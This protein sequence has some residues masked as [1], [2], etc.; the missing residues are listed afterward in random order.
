[1][2]EFNWVPVVVA[3]VGGG[4]AGAV[5]TQTVT[6]YRNRRQPVG[7]RIQVTPV[8]PPRRSP[9]EL[10]AAIAVTHGGQ[11]ATFENL[12]LVEVQLI[13]KGTPTSRNFDLA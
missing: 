9:G 6:T 3:L 12:F 1:M 10:E 7:R 8:F 2:A 4:A 13:N 5:I 11:R